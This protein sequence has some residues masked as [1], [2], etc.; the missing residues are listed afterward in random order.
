[1]II[2][3]GTDAPIYHRPAATFGLI[4]LNGLLYLVVPPAAYEDYSLVLGEGVHPH[5]W[6]TNT[7]LHSGLVHLLGNLVFLWTFGLVVEGKLGWWAFL[8]VYL[9][10]GVSE[11]AALQALVRSGQPVH[12]LGSSAIIFGLL[13][14]CLVWAPRNEVLCIVWLRLTPMEIELSILW[15]AVLY[16]GLDVLGAGMSGVVMANLT[17]RPGGLILALVLDHAFG[18]LLGFV[19]AVVLLKVKWVDCEDWDLF[20]LIQGRTG[21]SRRQSR[22]TKPVRRLV[23]SEWA[24]RSPP[25]ARR[26]RRDGSP[27]VRSVEDRSAAALRAMSHHLELGEVEAALAVYRKASRSPA[28]WQ[29]PEPDWRDLVEALLDQALWDD[30]VQVMRDYVRHQPEP[31]PRVRLKLAQIL[32]Q[33]LNRPLQ[34]LKILGEIPEGS[35]PEALEA[36][37]RQ[38]ARKAEAMREEGPLELEDEMW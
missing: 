22:R 3:W 5:Q 34:A 19:L 36:M 4:A 20:A 12:V 27:P 26:K 8:L 15:F 2:P 7:F 31:S 6:L 23:S 25:R 21:R 37:R 11:S 9:G 14:M 30:A 10:L 1:M 29:P 18:A 28:G 32:I 38:L 16:I 35:L 13:A 24:P 17:D 33:R